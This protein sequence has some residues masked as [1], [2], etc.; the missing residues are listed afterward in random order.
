MVSCTLSYT[1][2]PIMSPDNPKLDSFFQDF[3]VFVDIF[4]K[5]YNNFGQRRDMVVRKPK[6]IPLN[7]ILHRFNMIVVSGV[8][9]NTQKNTQNHPFWVIFRIFRH[10]QV[11]NDHILGH[12]P[13]PSGWK[14]IGVPLNTVSHRFNMV[15]VHFQ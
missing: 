8:T 15:T 4:R 7:T 12:L 13:T 5:N 11:L 10:F 14:P 1:V 2:H 3:V 9:R 6:I